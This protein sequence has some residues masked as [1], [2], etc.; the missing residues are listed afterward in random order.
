V[1]HPGNLAAIVIVLVG[2]LVL[3]SLLALIP[4]L[5]A[6]GALIWRTTTEDRFLHDNLDG[7]PEYAGRVRARLLPG[8]Y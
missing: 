6:A 5:V 4:Q 8:L 1:R 2:P 7:Y 3:N